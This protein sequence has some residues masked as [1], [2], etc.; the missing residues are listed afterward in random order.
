M[1]PHPVPYSCKG[2]YAPRSRNYRQAKSAED[3]VKAIQ[4]QMRQDQRAWIEISA[5]APLPAVIGQP[6][7]TN[8]QLVNK[9]KTPATH[10]V[11][12]AVLKQVKNGESPTFRYDGEPRQITTTGEMNPQQPAY[13]SASTG[14]WSKVKN[15]AV[16]HAV[17]QKEMDSL[18]AGDS[19]LITYVRVRYRDIFGVQHWSRFCEFSV[20]NNQRTY[21]AQKCTDYSSV[22][23]N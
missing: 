16:P 11:I 4:R 2:T 21:T 22:D 9:G 23:N 8:F 1:V 13:R 7:T 6:I 14:D 20:F 5:S 18:L 15:E 10:I 17:T 3:S 19:Y 12:E